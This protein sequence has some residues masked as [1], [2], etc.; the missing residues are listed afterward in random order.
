METVNYD[1]MN[2]VRQQT[3]Q[4]IIRKFMILSEV[5]ETLSDYSQVYV[6]MRQINSVL[7]DVWTR[8]HVKTIQI[9]STSKQEVTSP[10]GC[11]VSDLQEQ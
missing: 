8:L 6:T 4:E 3:K 11:G 5:K 10:D 7:S 1:C 9:R 2:P